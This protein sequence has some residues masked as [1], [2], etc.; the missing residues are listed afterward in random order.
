DP[1][2]YEARLAQARAALNA[3]IARRDAAKAGLAL[4]RVTAGAGVDQASAGVEAARSS[5]AQAR[6]AASAAEGRVNQLSA[7]VGAAEANVEQAQAQVTAAEAEA[8]R[9]RADA[10][11]KQSLFNE[12][13]V[14]RQEFE[15]TTAAA[16]PADPQPETGRRR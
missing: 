16:A 7:A 10:G 6:A 5:V 2:D 14:S 11:R 3:A 15:R 9:A 1:R 13:V 4:T 12:G 8:V